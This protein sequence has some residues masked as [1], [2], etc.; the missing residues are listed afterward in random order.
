MTR[1]D[2][3]TY[4]G[5]HDAAVCLG[6]QPFGKT[7]L[8]LWQEKTGREPSRFVESY[9]TQKGLYL[10]PL[11]CAWYE[12][13][14]GCQV[15]NRGDTF[16]KHTDEPVMAGHPDGLAHFAERQKLRLVEFKD[17]KRREYWHEP[18]E[19]YVAQCQH[20]GAILQ[21]IHGD[22]LEPVVDLVVD[23][24]DTEPKIFEVPLTPES[25]DWLVRCER[26]FWY[27]HVNKDVPPEPE[28]VAEAM[29][30]WPQS[31]DGVVQ[32]SPEDVLA[33]EQYFAAEAEKKK[34]DARMASAKLKLQRR[35]ADAGTLLWEGRPIVTWH[36]DKK[37]RRVYREEAKK[38]GFLYDQITEEGKPARRFL[39]KTLSDA[40]IQA[41]REQISE[42]T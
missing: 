15:Q 32:A 12:Q 33:L 42:V 39:P 13:Q 29:A 19:D 27:E 3:Q 37:G 35:L 8:Q 38:G 24:G 40:Q 34:A 30:T 28:N 25:I 9:R 1:P 16:L 6:L 7:K 14:R 2:P 11:L 23:I 17:T 4:L 22:V 10:E 20:Y 21:S 41:A 5:G 31:T 26:E 18:P 36:T